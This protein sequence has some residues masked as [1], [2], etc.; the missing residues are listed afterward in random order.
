MLV[1]NL[2]T[3]EGRTAE[4]RLKEP[5]RPEWQRPASSTASRSPLPISLLTARRCRSLA[6]AGDRR[7][8]TIAFR[9][10]LWSLGSTFSNTLGMGASAPFALSLVVA[11][12]PTGS[13]SYPEGKCGRPL[14]TKRHCGSDTIPR[15]GKVPQRTQTRT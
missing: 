12:W 3:P 10:H 2:P 7:D 5:A 15:R 1:V 13:R 11:L 8:A 4:Y 6:D 9:R 14:S